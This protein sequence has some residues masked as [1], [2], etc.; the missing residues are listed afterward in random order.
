VLNQIIQASVNR[1]ANTTLTNVTIENVIDENDF[2]NSKEDRKQIKGKDN[3]I[4]GKVAIV[5]NSND[6]NKEIINAKERTSN[7][8]GADQKDNSK[9][10]TLRKNS[11]NENKSFKNNFALNLSG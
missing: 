7:A 11:K 9:R 5:G 2:E 1:R 3:S 6:F 8:K 10:V 4:S